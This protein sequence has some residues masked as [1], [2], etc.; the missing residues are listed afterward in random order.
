MSFSTFIG[1]AAHCA[2]SAALDTLISQ[3]SDNW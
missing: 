1:T 3:Y 2:K